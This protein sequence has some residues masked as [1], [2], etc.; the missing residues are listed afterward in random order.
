MIDIIKSFLT[1]QIVINWIA[2]IITGLIVVAI[3]A[4][5]IRVFQ[6][7]KDKRKVEDANQRY[8][9]SIRPYIIQ[10]L[11][12]DKRLISDVRKV[13]IKESCIKEKYI[14][15]EIELRDKLILDITEDNY[16]NEKDKKDLSD[17]T[18]EVFSEFN[19]AQ[20]T[21]K[22][23]LESKTKTKSFM[24]I[25]K[26]VIILII[27]LIICTII[28]MNNR[29]GLDLNNN[30]TFGLSYI[31]AFFSLCIVLLSYFNKSFKSRV[32]NETFKEKFINLFFEEIEIKDKQ[33][34]KN[35]TTK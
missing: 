3:P 23:I 4:F 2:P 9:N 5:L 19:T 32:S 27:S 13:I 1:N 8:L 22:E 21:G 11:N 6:L 20:N 29:D 17:F 26:Y 35:K 16:I 15:T 33:K 12:I 24:F 10:K 25:D 30:M 18:Y 31:T 7:R 28:Q 34:Q 14:Y